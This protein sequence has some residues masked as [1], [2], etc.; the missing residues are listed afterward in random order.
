MCRISFELLYMIFLYCLFTS[1]CD[2]CVCFNAAYR[3]LCNSTARMLVE[4][5]PL[6][7]LYLLIFLN[8]VNTNESKQ[9]KSADSQYLN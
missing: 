4:T 1:A 8:K 6:N 9:K 7:S 5:E 2:G 3:V